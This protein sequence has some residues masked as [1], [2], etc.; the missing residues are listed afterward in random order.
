MEQYQ[1]NHVSFSVRLQSFGESK[2][3]TDYDTV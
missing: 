2:Q 3:A 1:N